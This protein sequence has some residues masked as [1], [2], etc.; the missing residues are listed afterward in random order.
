MMNTRYIFC[1][2]LC[3]LFVSNADAQ[4]WKKFKERTK[5]KIKERVEDKVVNEVS[6]DISNRAMQ[7]V[8]EI[9]EDLWRKTYNNANDED[10][11]EEEF[12]A[13][14]G[15][16]GGDLNE[17]LGELNKAADVPDRYEFTVIVDHSSTDEHG[18][19][20]KSE[21]YFSRTEGI[22][23]IL[24]EADNSQLITVLDADRDLMVMFN[25]K[26]GEKSA[27][28]IP[29]MFTMA[30]MLSMTSEEAQNYELTMKSAGGSKTIAG[31]SCRKYIAEDDES[32]FT[33]YI[34][35]ELPFDWRSSYGELLKSVV[36]KMYDENEN[37]LEG[38]IMQSTETNKKTGKKSHWVVNKISRL[39]TTIRKSEYTFTGI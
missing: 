2:V 32:T 23:G 27:Q 25:D 10:L 20:M 39:N 29:A 33:F 9:Y 11:S 19:K 7:K 13:M 31:Y 5:D 35:N 1:L 22:M 37:K 8:D 28:A 6:E 30:S 17:A 24:T 15:E 12:E 16:L 4:L 18:E 36:P 14:L 38:M 26:N 34:S 21:M 3:C